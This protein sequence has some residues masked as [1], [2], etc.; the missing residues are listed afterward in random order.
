M[1]VFTGQTHRCTSNTNEPEHDQKR[2]LLITDVVTCH[3]FS[4]VVVFNTNYPV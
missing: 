2:L 1:S 4:D 3:S